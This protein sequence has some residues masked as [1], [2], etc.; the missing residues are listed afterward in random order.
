MKLTT[1][2]KTMSDI[3]ATDLKLVT[4]DS[5]FYLG[6]VVANEEGEVTH[7]NNAILITNA[8]TGIIEWHD[9]EIRENLKTITITKGSKSITYQD[10][11]EDLVDLFDHCVIAKRKAYRNAKPDLISSLYKKLCKSE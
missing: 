3:K 8:R 9:A 2:E 10:L 4:I 5:Y 7:L 1:K 6:N 11:E